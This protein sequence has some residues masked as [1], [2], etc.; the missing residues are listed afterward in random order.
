MKAVILARGLGTRMRAAQDVAD[1]DQ[2]QQLAADTGVKAMIPVGRPFLDYS[3]SALADAGVRDVCLVIGPEHGLVREY[4]AGS[5]STKRVKI[6]FAVQHQPIGTADALLAAI[7]FVGKDDFLVLNSDNYY[8][9]SSLSR[10]LQVSAPA[11]AAFESDGLVEL[12]NV[13]RDRVH[14]FG[15]LEFTPGKCLERIAGDAERARKSGGGRIYCSMNCWF[16]T[17]PIFDACRSVPKSARDEFELTQAVQLA[18]NEMNYCVQ[19]IPLRDGV[20][21]MSSRS[22]IP[23]V[24]ERLGAIHCEP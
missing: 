11:I 3:L 10:L 5:G 17:P 18:I 1:L 6:H 23:G 16:F 24:K 7:Q 20:L 4:Y 9:A 19:V 8:P 13:P 14:R 12:G 15:A 22:D 2:A 21:D